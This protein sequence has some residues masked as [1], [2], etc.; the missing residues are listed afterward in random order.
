[1][2]RS[3]KQ[4]LRALANQG[5]TAAEASRVVASQR[6]PEEVRRMLSRYRTG[7]QRGRGG[8]PTTGAPGGAGAVAAG[9]PEATPTDSSPDGPDER[10]NAG[11]E[12][13]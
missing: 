11:E 5:G 6:S 4:Q 13:T 9:E 8:V 3:P 12:R 1:M 7:L 2:R 10:G